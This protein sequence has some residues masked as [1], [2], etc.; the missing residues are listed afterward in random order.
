MDSHHHGRLQRA[1]S[2]W[3]DDPAFGGTR[4]EDRWWKMA[5]SD[6]PFSIFYPP[7]SSLKLVARQG[8]A[9]CSIPIWNRDCITLMLAGRNGSPSRS[10]KSE[11]WCSR[12][13]LHL[14]WRRS[15]RRASALGY[16]SYW[17]RA[18]MEPPAGAAPT[19]L[20]YKGNPSRCIGTGK[21]KWSQSPVLPWTERA[22]ETCLSAGSTAVLAH[23]HHCGRP[24]K[25]SPHPEL[26][27]TD[28]LTER[29]HR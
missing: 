19:K 1:M 28:S 23:G 6:L 2:Y 13:D 10:S 20:H 17:R 11:G 27:R 9:P 21:R 3:L 26:Y 12:Q 4:M 14:H 24:Q 7:S 8:N 5:A 18:I 25:W 22:Y 15:R 29:M 16:A